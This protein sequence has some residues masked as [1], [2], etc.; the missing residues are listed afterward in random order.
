MSLKIRIEKLANH[1]GGHFR[2]F[3]LGHVADVVYRSVSVDWRFRGAAC[4]DYALGDLGVFMI[5]FA[6]YDKEGHVESVQLWP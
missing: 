5:L 4:I 6:G 2:S 3:E 1:F